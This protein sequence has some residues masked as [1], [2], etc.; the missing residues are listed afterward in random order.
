MKVTLEKGETLDVALVEGDR[1]VGTLS[2]VL[3]G[4]GVGVGFRGGAEAPAAEMAAPSARS[5][6]GARGTS[7]ARRKRN[8]SPEARAKMADAQ[9]RRW[10]KVRQT[11]GG[12]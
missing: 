10:E 2:L 1:I 3:R 6:R 7:S 8:I 11:K 12:K 5:A 9:R 4:A